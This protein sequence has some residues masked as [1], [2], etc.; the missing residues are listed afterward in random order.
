MSVSIKENYTTF[1]IA[2]VNGRQVILH[3]IDEIALDRPGYY[4]GVADGQKFEIF[5]GKRAGGTSRDWF[6]QWDTLGDFHMNATSLTDAIRLIE[7]A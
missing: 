7:T 4:S 3:R 5:G 2:Q 1:K 6:V